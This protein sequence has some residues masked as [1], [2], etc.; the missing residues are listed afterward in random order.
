M[1]INGVEIPKPFD[2]ADLRPTPSPGFPGLG[3]RR[4]SVRASVLVA[5]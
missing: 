3:G 1:S 4:P 2:G 5:S